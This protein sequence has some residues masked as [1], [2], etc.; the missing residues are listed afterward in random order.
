MISKKDLNIKNKSSRKDFGLNAEKQ[1]LTQCA[2]DWHPKVFIKT[3]GCQV[4]CSFKKEEN[5]KYKAR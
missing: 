3:F 4:I 2:S 5:K 1:P